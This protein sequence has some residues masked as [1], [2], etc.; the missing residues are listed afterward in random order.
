M[1]LMAVLITACGDDEETQ[2]PDGSSIAAGRS[3]YQSSCAVCHGSGGEGGVGRALDSVAAD[4]PE[5]AEQVRWITLGSSRWE[6]E[7][8]PT[9]GVSARP[10]AG[11]MPEFEDRLTEAEIKAVSAFTRARFGGQPEAEALSDCGA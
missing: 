10:V 4:F 7:V 1:V 2:T 3:V 5:C 9:Y 11:G 8:G 6:D